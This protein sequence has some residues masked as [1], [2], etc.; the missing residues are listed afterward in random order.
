[1]KPGHTVRGLVLVLGIW[2][3]SVLGCTS[4]N[5]E[6]PN[7]VSCNL[8]DRQCGDPT[9][10]PQV[11]MVCGRDASDALGFIEEPCPTATLCDS[12]LCT[13]AADTTGC[14]S[15]TDC[16]AGQVCVP[17][18]SSAASPTLS[19]YCVPAASA[20]AAPGAACSKDSDCQSY[21]C[22]QYPRGRY[23]LQTCAAQPSCA[24]SSPCRAL[25]V[26][27]NGVQGSILSCSP[28]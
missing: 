8:G 6:Y 1:M 15:Q 5:P 14:Q 3:S 10:S 16:A 26:T 17:L 7:P 28:Q 13:P 25:S 9:R 12:G 23:C 18:V 19:T 27:V 24:P 21:R 22:L 4:T 20:A 2:T 11:A